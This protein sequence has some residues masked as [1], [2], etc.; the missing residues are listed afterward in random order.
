MRLVLIILSSLKDPPCFGVFVDRVNLNLFIIVYL[1]D[2][3]V[4][5]YRESIANL[6]SFGGE[7]GLGGT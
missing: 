2:I 5:N 7:E 6:T 1:N 3:K 4:Y